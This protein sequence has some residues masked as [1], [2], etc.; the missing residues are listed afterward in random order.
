[1]AGVI[2]TGSNPKLLWPGLQALWGQMYPQYPKEWEKLF[3]V[4]RSTKNYEQDV[5]FTTFGLVP[6]KNEGDA[7]YYDTSKQGF[8]TTY[9]NVTYAMGFIITQEMIEDDQYSYVSEKSMRALTFSVNQ[10]KNIVG[11]NI[12]NRATSV[13]QL[14][15]DGK[16]LLATD[17]P[18]EAGT[19]SN[20]LD[21]PADLSENSLEQAVIGIQGFTD[22]RGN[23]L[24]LAPKALVVPKELQFEAVRLLKNENRPETANRDIN[25]LYAL[26]MY[27][28]SPEVN[29]FLT[30]PDAWFVLTNCPDGLKMY[31]RVDASI[32]KD[33]DFDTTN[34]KV[35]CRERYCFY[36]TDPRGIFGSPG[37]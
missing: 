30:D 33:N 7:I 15:G 27:K 14:G 25:A 6:P 17:H 20:T 8:V 16:P 19:F 12:L 23:I 36:W 31:Q 18:L 11:A 22:S 13:S 21:T 9:T 28:S 5:S 34:L 10:T 26:N 32:D 3:E 29:H 1:M 4:K 24:M 35:K 2:T 37:A